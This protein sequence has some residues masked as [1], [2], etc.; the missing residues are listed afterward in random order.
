VVKKHEIL[1]NIEET[2]KIANWYKKPDISEFEEYVCNSNF[3][4]NDED[5]D[6]E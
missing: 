2:G 1:I 3:E 4:Y 5:D 6:D